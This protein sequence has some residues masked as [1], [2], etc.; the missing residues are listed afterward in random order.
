M[1]EVFI[2]ELRGQ[3]NLPR[4]FSSLF[5][6]LKDPD[7]GSLVIQLQDG[8]Q[9]MVKGKTAGAN[10]KIIVKNENFFSRL[11]RE[12]QNGFSEAYMD[13]WWDTPDLQAVLDFFLMAG[14]RLYE[15]L[16]GASIVRFYERFNHW[17]RSNWKFQAKKNIAYHYDL[18]NQFYREWLDKTMT[19]SSALFNNK[20]E[21]LSQAQANKY[22]EICK[23]IRL[24]EGDNILEIGCG[25]GGFAEHAIKTRGATVTGLTLSKEQLEYSKKRMFDLG[26]AEKSNFLLK[27]YRD[28]NG[29]YDGVVSIEMFEA[30][31]EK[32]WPIYFQKIKNVLK[33]NKFGC[34]QIITI[35]EKYFP[36]YRKSVDFLQ[37]Y[38]F[39]GG[40]LPSNTALR[41]QLDGAD[42]EFISSNE[43]GQSYSKT[44]RIWNE[45]FNSKWEKISPMGFDERFNRMWNFYLTSCASF[46]FSGAGNVT[47]ITLKK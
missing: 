38:I 34:L 35:D 3:A 4:W 36:K 14:D 44:L 24:K 25:W 23:S 40:M 18:G 7:F 17:L 26:L 39:P 10:A 1:S 2:N 12:G 21:P 45:S 27:D 19:Y 22:E 11:V 9:F 29:L 28:E 20:Q 46:F 41:E 37:K 31:G 6:M 32:Y 33:P 8:R 5:N 43:F 16:I 30:V 15:E 13:G 42:L 47:Q